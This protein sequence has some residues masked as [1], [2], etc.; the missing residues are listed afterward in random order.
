MCPYYL[1]GDRRAR[2]REHGRRNQRFLRVSAINAHPDTQYIGYCAVFKVR[3]EAQ[4]RSTEARDRS[5]ASC[6]R[7]AGLSKLNSMRCDR[8]T[9]ITLGESKILP[10]GM[11]LPFPRFGRH[12]LV[13]MYRGTIGRAEPKPASTSCSD[14]PGGMPEGHPGV[15]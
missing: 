5:P 13:R 4:A 12:L 11:A 1:D 9:A 10:V 6:R 3:E 8:L 7:R 2:L 14:S 15:L